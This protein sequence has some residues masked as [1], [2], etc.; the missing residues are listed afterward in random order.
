MMKTSPIFTSPPDSRLAVHLKAIRLQLPLPLERIRL[1]DPAALS[2]LREKI[3]A[4]ASDKA[5]LRLLADELGSLE[6]ASLFALLIQGGT[7]TRLAR[8]ITQIIVLRACPTLYRYG[9]LTWQIHY[10]SP[11][12]AGA[13]AAL[14][15]QLAARPA[16]GVQQAANLPLISQIVAPD[17][18]QFIRC[19]VDRLVLI[20]LSLD[21]FMRQYQLDAASPLGQSVIAAYFTDEN[22]PAYVYRQ[23]GAYFS[24]Y[25]SQAS[26]SQQAVLLAHFLNRTAIEPE[27]RNLFCQLVYRQIG[28]PAPIGSYRP[29]AA[30]LAGDFPPGNEPVVPEPPH[31]VWGKL[32]SHDVRLFLD[33]VNAATIGSH[34]RE[35]PDKARLYLQ[36]ADRIVRLEAWDSE[37]L[38][39]VFP[40]FLIADSRKQ[41][42]LALYYEQTGQPAGR[43]LDLAG[44][45]YNQGPAYAAIPH[46]QVEDAVRH[47]NFR[48]IIGLRFDPQGIQLTQAF[49]SLRLKVAAA[50]P[51]HSGRPPRSD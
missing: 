31:A 4:A 18:R 8:R 9:W 17:T 22:A 6:I 28:S 47:L 24:Q 16:A 27:E 1:P 23:N 51:G 45:P 35:Q 10:P 38:L 13:L 39:I 21:A 5:A 19:L 25:L 40:G 30:L 37:T 2:R 12:V 3:A 7:S 11:P 42:H 32:S 29:A 41:P 48:G 15:R 33:W 46:R 49:L 36:Y 50:S 44:S 43:P 34:C 20:G 14:C 26:L